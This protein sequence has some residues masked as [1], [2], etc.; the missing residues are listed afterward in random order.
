MIDKINDNV[1]RVYKGPF[2]NLNSIKNEFNVINKMN[3]D[4]IDIIKL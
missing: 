2:Y 4:S 1:Y 3:F